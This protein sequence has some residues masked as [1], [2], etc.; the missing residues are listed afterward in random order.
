MNI[1][2]SIENKNESIPW[3]LKIRREDWLLA[4]SLASYVIQFT[5]FS[6]RNDT[7]Y[8]TS[9]L[10]GPS[11][12]AY[13][14]MFYKM[15]HGW[16]SYC[17]YLQLGFCCF[18]LPGMLSFYFGNSNQLFPL[19]QSHTFSQNCSVGTDPIRGGEP[20]TKTK[21]GREAYHN[22]AWLGCFQNNRMSQVRP[23]GFQDF[24]GTRGNF[25]LWD[26][27]GTV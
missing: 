20:M 18:C 19:V 6:K 25:M 23:T 9:F 2:W 14:N 16:L 11:K 26:S 22:P 10:W 3:N 13:E 21:L 8:P 15:I 17:Y 7:V 1:Q 5:H 24:A 12:K 4:L 27:G